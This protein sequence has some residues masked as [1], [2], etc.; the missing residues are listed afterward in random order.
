M[1]NNKLFPLTWEHYGLLVDDLW[2]DL[3]TKLEKDD[4]KIDAVVAIL[5]EGMFT[6]YAPLLQIKYL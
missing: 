1:T 4:I 6:C 5:R 3:K 2:R